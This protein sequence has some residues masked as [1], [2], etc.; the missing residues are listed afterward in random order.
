[1]GVSTKAPDV[2]FVVPSYQSASTI[3]MTLRS[4]REQESSLSHEIVVVDSSPDGRPA[5]LR[6]RYPDLQ[7]EHNPRRLWPGA[8]RNL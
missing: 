2:S 8:A 5:T 6:T 3:E 7:V 4:I 1:M